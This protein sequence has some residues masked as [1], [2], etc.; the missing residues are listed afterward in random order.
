ML[1]IHTDSYM[2]YMYKS[3]IPNVLNGQEIV[4]L[5]HYVSMDDWEMEK[6]TKWDQIYMLQYDRLFGK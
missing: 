3:E 5:D 4:D 2:D 1:N 6:K